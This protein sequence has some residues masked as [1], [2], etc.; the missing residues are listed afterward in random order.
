MYRHQPPRNVRVGD[1]QNELPEGN[2][3]LKRGELKD[4]RVRPVDGHQFECE[5]W[6]RRGP[7]AGGALGNSNVSAGTL[8]R[9]L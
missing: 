9:V 6:L 3:L 8:K 4:V 1:W 7:V 2:E 5:I